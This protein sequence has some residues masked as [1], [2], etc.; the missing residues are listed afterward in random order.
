M[1]IN[2]TRF[3][4]RDRDNRYFLNIPP[5]RNVSEDSWVEFWNSFSAKCEKPTRH[6]VFRWRAETLFFLLLF[7][8]C[9]TVTISLT[10]VVGCKN[11]SSMRLQVFPRSLVVRITVPVSQSSSSL[12]IR[13]R[14]I[15]SRNSRWINRLSARKFF[16]SLG[17]TLG[18]RLF[19]ALY[20]IMFFSHACASPSANSNF[21]IG[22]HVR[23]RRYLSYSVY[24][25]NL[26]YRYKGSRCIERSNTLIFVPATAFNGV[27]R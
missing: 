18:E 5:V 17:E 12:G 6:P 7:F 10:T 1:V 13:T 25:L 19:V 21:A 14:S 23:C 2:L 15:K 26:F 20:R 8:W 4:T 22:V 16:L 9:R 27:L 11:G 3:T 24:P